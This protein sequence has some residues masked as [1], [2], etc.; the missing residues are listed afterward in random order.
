MA[1]HSKR[2]L[3]SASK[4]LPKTSSSSKTLWYE[5]TTPWF[6]RVRIIAIGSAI[7]AVAFLKNQK[8]YEIVASF[9]GSPDKGGEPG[10]FY[11]VR[12]RKV[13]RT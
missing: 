2:S 3:E 1:Y 9:P 10:I 7:I 13:E 6:L 11:H 4:S 5:C 8:N 12:D